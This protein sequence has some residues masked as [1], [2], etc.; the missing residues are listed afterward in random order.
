MCLIAY[1]NKPG[2]HIPNA[3]IE[4][5]LKSNPD[6]FGIA[7]RDP[8]QGLLHAKFAPSESS[9]FVELLKNIDKTD[10]VYTAHWRTG[11]H[12]PNN[13]ELAHPFP[14]QDN[15]GNEIL[16]FHNGIISIKTSADE[17]DT[18]MFVKYVLS[19]LKGKW[20]DDDAIMF[21]VESSIGWSRMLLMTE[22]EDVFINE[23]QWK[24]ENGISYS[25]APG[26]F[27]TKWVTPGTPL[28]TATAGGAAQGGKSFRSDG[29]A[30]RYG[31]GWASRSV[32]LDDEYE[33]DLRN[34]FAS[35]KEGKRSVPKFYHKGHPCTPSTQIDSSSETSDDRYGVI[36]CDECCTDGEYF[37]IDGNLQIDLEH[38]SDL[39]Y[40]QLTGRV[41]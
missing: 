21:L 23:D 7:W 10:M 5:N 22:D 36:T 35:K 30:S 17:S 41:N 40:D 8:E 12:G 31:G 18:S 29:Y 15:D 4:Y 38:M 13:K 14:Y 26:P 1:R 24:V 9:Q 27:A 39:L 28:L 25:T 16:A 32:D 37:I 20:W 6:G 3:V 34:V 33:D 2:S 11:T 19:G